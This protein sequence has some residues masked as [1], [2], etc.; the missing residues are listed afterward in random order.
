M[1]EICSVK[2]FAENSRKLKFSKKFGLVSYCFEPFLAYS[3]GRKGPKMGLE[4]YGTGPGPFYWL[5]F[6]VAL[7]DTERPQPKRPSEF[8]INAVQT[9]Y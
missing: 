3:A 5:S 1:E 2:E 7:D 4:G 9:N 8:F 6:A